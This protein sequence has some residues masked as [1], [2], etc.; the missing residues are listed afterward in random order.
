MS[1]NL[2]G[3]LIAMP[4]MPVKDAG[5]VPYGDG[6]QDHSLKK[7][8]KAETW[9]NGYLL[10]F[11]EYPTEDNHLQGITLGVASPS[12]LDGLA[13]SPWNG[14]TTSLNPFLPVP[15]NDGTFKGHE[16]SGFSQHG[17]WEQNHTL[18]GELKA[19]RGPHGY[20]VPVGYLPAG[21]SDRR[22]RRR[23]FT[24]GEKMIIS[25]KRKVGVC[26]DC[27]HAKRKASLGMTSAF[28]C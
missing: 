18:R 11:S 20:H 26:R 6:E 27:R 22:R 10:P 3:S 13:Y 14:S 2:A 12:R 23:R 25:Y 5:L 21:R 15:T 8:S 19:E 9:P 24:N 4:G 7:H 17:D 16:G 28:F 1:G